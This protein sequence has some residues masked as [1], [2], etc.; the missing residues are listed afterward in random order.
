MGIND[1]NENLT[2]EKKD[3]EINNKPVYYKARKTIV[4]I[5]NV[6]L[7]ERG[8]EIDGGGEGER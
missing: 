7:R 8:G 3:K 4:E 1:D 6:C 2:K 5:V